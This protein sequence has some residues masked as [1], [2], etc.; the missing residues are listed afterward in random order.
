MTRRPTPALGTGE[1]RFPFGQPATARP[2][3]RS[4]GPADLF[5]LGVYPSAL[6]VAWNPPAWAVDRLGVSRV[7]ALAVDDE[8]TVFWDGADADDRVDRW[9]QACG[10]LTGDQPGQWGRVRPAGNGTS[11]RSVLDGVLTPLDVGAEACWFTDV[12]DRYFIKGGTATRR[13]QVEAME[14]SYGRF[15]T[16]AGLP[17]ASLPHRPTPARLVRLAV[18]E[19][20]ARLRAELIEAS[21]PTVVTLGEEARRVLAAIAD[22][23]T[24]PPAEALTSQRFA[25]DPDLY[26]APGTVHIEGWQARWMALAHPGQRSPT[27]RHLHD[28]WAA[29]RP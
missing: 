1:W 4:S 3:R 14:H 19:H 21:A 17:P 26:G 2:P 20:R 12:V 10:F 8:P 9:M 23:T 27:W 11:G 24:G 6:H 29:S 13:G 7:A 22:E 25:T 18:D 16:A 28:R 5:V 15:A